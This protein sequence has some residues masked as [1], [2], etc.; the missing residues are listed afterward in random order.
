MRRYHVAAVAVAA[1]A[2]IKWVDNLVSRFPLTG[3][4]RAGNGRTRHLGLDAVRQIV[5][6]RSLSQDLGM[7]L[8]RAVELAA[9][10]LREPVGVEVRHVHLRAKLDGLDDEIQA[11]LAAGAERL[12]PPKRGRPEKR[13]GPT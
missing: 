8:G 9:S 3:V 7:S 11:R 1:N 5:L 2:E 6:V 13:R 4:A 12:V 10:M